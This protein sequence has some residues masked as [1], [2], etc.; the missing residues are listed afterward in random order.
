MTRSRTPG[1]TLW[2][3]G[4]AAVSALMAQIYA[5]DVWQGPSGP[6]VHLEDDN[7]ITLRVAMTMADAGVPYFNPGEAVAANTSLFWPLILAPFGRLLGGASL[8]E[9]LF[10]ASTVMSVAA[11]MFAAGLAGGR[12]AG[13][14]LL[15]A[16]L[17]NPGMVKYGGSGWEHIPQ[18][19]AL[20]L[21]FSAILANRSRRFD[22]DALGFG[23]IC[24]GFALRPDAA[25]LA[26]GTW[27]FFALSHLRSRPLATLA[28]S[29]AGLAVPVVYVV[30]MLTWY[31]DVVPNTYHLKGAGL[32]ELNRGLAYLSTPRLSGLVPALSLLTLVLVFRRGALAPAGDRAV[33]LILLLHVASTAFS[34]GDVFSAGRFYLA[35]LPIAFVLLVRALGRMHPQGGVGAAALLLVLGLSM[36]VPD[37]RGPLAAR[38][39]LAAGNKMTS[40]VAL[41]AVIAERLSPDDG[42][43]GLHRLGQGYHLRA[44][45][46]VDFLG[47]AE[48]HIART[49][50]QRGPKGHN[51]WDY[52]H[53]FD[54]YRIAAAPFPMS[55]ADLLDYAEL[56]P[57]NWMYLWIFGRKLITEGDYTLLTPEAL[58]LASPHWGLFVRNDLVERMMPQ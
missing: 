27:V 25:V 41:T 38:D 40:H 23:A 52:E 36:G 28:V 4:L 46:V 37:W 13:V 17:L 58:G 48:T 22:L 53:A 2:L 31:G 19:L 55:E 10:Y 57:H 14:F 1:A 44:F 7:M 35:L 42:S 3:L 29:V 21:G 6:V 20:T 12:A 16:I 43:I 26:A 39:T 18:M 54:T 50:A 34:G 51:K 32:G 11:A 45:H 49:P 5:A 24:L 33:A 8:P 9:A 56:P 47:K 30:L 15:A